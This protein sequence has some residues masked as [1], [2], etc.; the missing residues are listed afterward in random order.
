[1]DLNLGSLSISEEAHTFLSGLNF[2]D[3]NN[4]SSNDAPFSA[5]VEAFRFAFAL[6]YSKK[7]KK[8]PSGP[9]KGVAPRQFTV[10]DYV[11][12]LQNEIDS[13]YSSLG[14]LV[15]AYAEAGAEI[16]MKA[17]DEGKSILTLLD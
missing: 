3:Q 4:N 9:T 2:N 11:D 15:S 17:H 7:L 14:G 1:M 8:K 6:G 12:I 5:I 16:M 10:M 13:E